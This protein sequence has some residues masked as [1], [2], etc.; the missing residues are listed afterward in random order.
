MNDAAETA[1]TISH[2]YRHKYQH[3]RADKLETE[4]DLEF[5]EGFDNYI[6]AEDDYRGY[7]EQLVESDARAYA[8]VVKER[9]ASYSDVDTENNISAKHSSLGTEFSKLN[10]EKGAVFEKVSVDELSEDFEQKDRSAYKE[11]LEAQELDELRSVA[12][13]HYENGEAVWGKLGIQELESYKEHND[14]ENG[15]I[16]K[17]RVKSLEAADT[18]EAHFDKNNY[19]G[20]YSS[21]IDRRTIEVMSIYHDTGMDGNIKAENYEAERAAYISDEK[22][23]AKYVADAVSKKEKA[24]IEA[25]EPFDRAAEV[26]KAN[27]KFE[28]EGFENHFRPN[29]SLESAIH[30][31]RDREDI[32][33]LDVSADEVALGCLVHSKSNSGLRNIA[34]E[35]D[36]RVAVSRLQDR[37]DEF[38]QS[39]PD[40]QIHFDSSFLMNEDGS[41]KQD[42]L[43]EMRSEAIVLRIGDA[44]GHDTNSR[45]SQTG[46]SIEFTLEEKAVSDEL[47]SDFESK[48]ENG[49]YEAFFI[50]VQ[51]ADVK[52]DGT[53]L[54]N[55]NDP[56]GFS[57][58]FAVGEGNFQSLNCEVDEIGTIKQNF[59]LCDGNA[60]PLSTQ[61]CIEERLGEYK[62]AHPMNYT[63]V[64]KLGSNCSD[65]V[66]KSYLEFADKIEREYNVRM[67]VKR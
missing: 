21:N 20:L 36:W 61:H 41:F 46:K 18:L 27:E 37:V 62:T 1:D 5:K 9:I 53:E 55:A 47:P 2:E 26:V 23:R 8:Q 29:H 48:F 3:E 66:Y 14:I 31:L 59:E 64:V 63:P 6:R 49:D 58:M 57:R 60:F 67:E 43:A 28:R 39:H 12:G 40:E 22:I 50:E 42:K 32:N 13:V 51:A 52:V 33:R 10:P 24:A 7:K 19:D 15:H 44:N 54:N 4:R 56:K 38:N 16:E 30:A 17:V 34:S 65:E 25:G 11:V 35:D 45:T